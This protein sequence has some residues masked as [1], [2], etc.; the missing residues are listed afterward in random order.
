MFHIWPMLEDKTFV[1]VLLDVSGDAHLPV[2][3]VM[4]LARTYVWTLPN[5]HALS[6]WDHRA[7]G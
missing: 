5:S 1:V 6:V 3:L 2:D 7:L 4:W